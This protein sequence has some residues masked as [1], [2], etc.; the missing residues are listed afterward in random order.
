MLV[1]KHLF[2]LREFEF[3]VLIKTEF[4][5]KKKKNELYYV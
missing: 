1:Y 3:L 4:I 5:L 2:L